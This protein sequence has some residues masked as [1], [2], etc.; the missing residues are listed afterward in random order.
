MARMVCRT[1]GTCLP[2][3]PCS[4]VHL[5]GIIFGLVPSA[6]DTACTSGSVARAQDDHCAENDDLQIT[7]RIHTPPPSTSAANHRVTRA[8][9]QIP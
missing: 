9:R 7:A 6:G 3:R 2:Q 8:M 5:P 1:C 4:P